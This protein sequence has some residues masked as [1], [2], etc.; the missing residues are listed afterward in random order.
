MFFGVCVGERE[1]GT[2]TE[3]EKRK[4]QIKHNLGIY[5]CG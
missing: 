5:V 1:G 4:R 3:R 2:D